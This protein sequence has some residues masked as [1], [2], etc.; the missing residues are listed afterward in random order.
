M[1]E[2]GREAGGRE[3]A[4]RIVLMSGDVGGRVVWGVWVYY[5]HLT[6]WFGA[7]IA[8]SIYVNG[9]TADCPMI[10]SGRRNYRVHKA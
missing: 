3:G 9:T 6:S 4:W 1:G 2:G 7:W 10:F 8:E 5:K